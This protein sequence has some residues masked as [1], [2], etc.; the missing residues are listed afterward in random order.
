MSMHAHHG[1]TSDFDRFTK[2]VL[3][4]PVLQSKLDDTI[5]PGRFMLNASAAARS[6]GF[7]L[8]A[9]AFR[10]GSR[11]P[12]AAPRA[13]WAPTDWVPVG[14]HHGP[15]GPVV[16]WARIGPMPIDH[17]FY[18]D[19][20]SALTVRP[21]NR[22]F[23]HSTALDDFIR[24]S[25]AHAPA[26]LAGFVFHM[27]RCGSTLVSQMLGALPRTIALS[28]PTPL[29]AV[30]R[31]ILQN[32]DLP[33]HRRIDLLRAMVAALSRRRQGEARCFIKLDSWH[34]LALPLFRE[35]FPDVPWL[36][37]FR[38]P[39]EVLVSHM[40][41]RGY[42]TVPSLMPTGI[43]G[44]ADT[45]EVSP[46]ALCA[47]ILAQYHMAAIEGLSHGDGIAIDY[48]SLPRTFL[49]HID[50]HFRL[51]LS[52]EDRKAVTHR[53]AY[54]AKSTERRFAPDGA[55]K[56]RSVTEAASKAAEAHLAGPH[57]L[58]EALAVR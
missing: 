34:I 5:D 4:D 6:M 32:A 26:P 19:T 49:S 9:E 36:Y 27:S 3:A 51:N 12:Y 11:R 13:G 55:A 2:V 52:P 8:E 30:L 35:A 31:F 44:A 57:A 23:R 1:T 37:L 22:V 54:D 16:D 29:D 18:A 46:E 28:E 21:F 17:S 40:R 45:Q 10:P 24:S 42:Q 7:L 15:T 56:R 39:R 38:E 14:F 25:G 33:R 48:G 53:A 20:V 50:S 43:Y 58:L 47:R 41:M